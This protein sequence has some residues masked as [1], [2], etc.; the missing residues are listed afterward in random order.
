MNDSNKKDTVKAINAIAT[1]KHID[2]VIS[3]E[4]VRRGFA[5][6]NR[7][8]RKPLFGLTGLGWDNVTVKKGIVR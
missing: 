1:G 6:V 5:V 7:D 3:S 4:M 8:P 2:V